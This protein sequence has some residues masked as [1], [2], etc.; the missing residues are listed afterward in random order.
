MAEGSADDLPLAGIGQ[1]VAVT[2]TARS[3][4]AD[5]ERLGPRCAL[6]HLLHRDRYHP[7]MVVALAAMKVLAAV[8]AITD[9]ASQLPSKSLLGDDR[10][11]RG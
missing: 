4:H 8:A 2:R 10:A 5:P 6:H 9:L 11:P 3:A 7:S 1:A